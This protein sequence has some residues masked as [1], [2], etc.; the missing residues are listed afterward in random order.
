MAAVKAS[1]EVQ[2]SLSGLAGGAAGV[3]DAPRGPSGSSEGAAE[4]WPGS[5]TT[6][7]GSLTTS[8]GSLTT[9]VADSVAATSSVSLAEVVVSPSP[10]AARSRARVARIR[11]SRIVRIRRGCHPPIRPHLAI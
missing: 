1:T 2:N 7:D 9:S 10:Q 8:D 6:S 11:T 5:L 3:S 4:P